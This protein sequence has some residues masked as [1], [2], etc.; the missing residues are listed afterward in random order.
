MA[1]DNESG[2]G[3]DPERTDDDELCQPYDM[4]MSRCS[5]SEEVGVLGNDGA[6]SEIIPIPDSETILIRRLGI[7]ALVSIVLG[8]TGVCGVVVDKV[9]G[10]I[11]AGNAVNECL[12]NSGFKGALS[13]QI[14]PSTESCAQPDD[15]ES[16]AL[17][18]DTKTLVRLAYEDI[19]KVKP[20][21]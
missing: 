13:E 19:K 16:Y 21:Y 9:R 1:E 6:D 4:G 17:I 5:F 14:P 2:E 20:V 18:F 8:L 7:A 11:L 15:G 12:I 3:G 10:T